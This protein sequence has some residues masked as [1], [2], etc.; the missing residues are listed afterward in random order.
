MAA[1]ITG[2]NGNHSDIHDGNILGFGTKQVQPVFE[3]TDVKSTQRKVEDHVYKPTNPKS[4]SSVATLPATHRTVFKGTLAVFFTNQ[5]KISC[6]TSAI[7]W[8]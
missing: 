3:S 6:L 8:I 2:E 5:T 4:A 7:V 1:H